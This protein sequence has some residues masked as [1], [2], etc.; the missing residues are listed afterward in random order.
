MAPEAQIEETIAY[1]YYEEISAGLGD[2]LLEE[3]E[4]CYPKIKDN[5]FH[6]SF[7]ENSNILRQIRVSRFPYVAIFIFSS[8][9]VTILS[10]RHTKRKPFI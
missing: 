4:K 7:I 5:P 9:I 10:V 3:L 6:F 1:N 8:D 2:D